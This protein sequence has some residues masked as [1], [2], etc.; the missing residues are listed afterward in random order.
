MW[1]SAPPVVNGTIVAQIQTLM[2]LVDDAHGF[3]QRLDLPLELTL[4]FDELLE[5]QTDG[6]I[7]AVLLPQQGP[8]VPAHE[9]TGEMLADKNDER[10]QTGAGRERYRFLHMLG[11]LQVDEPRTQTRR[12]LGRHLGTPLPDAQPSS[13]TRSRSIDGF[14][15]E[16]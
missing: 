6:A 9:E 14:L 10:C 3:L 4:S 12:L 16:V 13:S 8:G 7:E 5:T 2:A 11:A 15:L 1:I